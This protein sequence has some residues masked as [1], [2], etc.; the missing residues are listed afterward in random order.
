MALGR[1]GASQ[2]AL[3]PQ[4]SPST[5]LSCWKGVDFVN[6]SSRIDD[7]ARGLPRHIC[8]AL[9]CHPLSLCLLHPLLFYKLFLIDD[10]QLRLNMS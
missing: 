4:A 7:G 1:C 2:V 5:N 9:E 10:L 3:G 6:P 8:A